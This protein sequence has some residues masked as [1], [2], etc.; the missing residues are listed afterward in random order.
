[1]FANH[2]YQALHALDLYSQQELDLYSQQESLVTIMYK[3]GRHALCHS[4]AMSTIIM[5]DQVSKGLG[6]WAL[7]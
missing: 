4:A 5:G 1:M 6:K 2:G 7:I 3:N